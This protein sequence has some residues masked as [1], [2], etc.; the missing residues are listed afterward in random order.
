MKDDGGLRVSGMRVRYG[1]LTA[2]DGVSF[3]IGKGEIL[4]L[5]GESGSGKSSVGRA[6][7][8][9]VPYEGDVTGAGP[10][11]MVFQD[12][13]G[14]LNPRLRIGDAVAEG[15]GRGGTRAVR[16]AEG[17]RLLGLVGLDEGVAGRYP[18]ELS[19]GQRQRVALARALGARPSLLI[20]DEI[21]SALDVSVQGAVL[22]LVREL[23]GRLGLSV[24]F[25]SHD[26]AVVRYVC[27]AVAVMREGRIVESGTVE[28]VTEHPGHEYTKALLDAVPRLR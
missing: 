8:G 9:L 24:L 10:T 6:L 23:R 27:D 3:T 18:R 25:V 4:G 15:L 11:Q 7:A 12:P 26:L 17:L 16:K 28:H 13:Y 1:D 20:A 22:N 21:T 14:S 2:V 5:V 19:G